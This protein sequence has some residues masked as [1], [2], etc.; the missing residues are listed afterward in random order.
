M[1]KDPLGTAQVDVGAGD[2]RL[3][4]LKGH[5]AVHGVQAFE[6][7]GIDL[8]SQELFQAEHTGGHKCQFHFGSFRIRARIRI[9]R[10]HNLHKAFSFF[11][12]FR[13]LVD[14]FV[15]YNKCVTKRNDSNGLR[16]LGAF[17]YSRL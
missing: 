6:S 12:I 7:Q 9:L 10:S 16:T 1:D 8:L 5:T 2:I 4:S 11:Q 17:P 14:T 3:G 13:P 15:L